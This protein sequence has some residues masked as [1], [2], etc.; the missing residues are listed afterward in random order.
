MNM[1]YFNAEKTR[2]DLVK[3]IKDWFVENELNE[4]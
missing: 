2:D 4:W 1:D 3:W